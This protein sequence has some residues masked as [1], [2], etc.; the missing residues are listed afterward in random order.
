[1]SSPSP[2]AG[3]LLTEIFNPKKLAEFVLPAR[4]TGQF[5]DET[6]PLES[7]YLFHSGPGMGKS[8]LAKFLAKRHPY[9]YVNASKEG[10]IDVL[11]TTIQDFCSE[12]QFPEEGVDDR[13]KVVILD[14]ID[15]IRSDAFY[16]ALRGF[17]DSFGG[18]VRFIATCNILSKV[19]APAQSRFE[20]IDFTAATTQEYEELYSRYTA[21]IGAIAGKA[22]SIQIAPDVLKVL[23]DNHFP[24]F[25][26]SLNTLQRFRRL[27]T[28]VITLEDLTRKSYE[29]KELYDTILAGAPPAAFHTL[30]MGQYATQA[31]EVLES[32]DNNF[33]DYVVLNYPAFAYMIPT[34]L[35]KVAL[36]S[37][38]ALRMDPALAMKACAFE[39]SQAA[40]NGRKN[41]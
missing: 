10:R 35:V 8:A 6:H 19:P 34:I 15:G 21:R 33:I 27:D 41:G 1:M 18:A 31:R 13:I 3:K 2:T 5:A 25:R 30:L 4:I 40:E 14:E 9:L 24:D 22:L 7:H 23:V 26:G 29:F 37:D 39:L 16:D 11:R 28:K 38:M 17:M 20:K 32:L 36:Y 12:A